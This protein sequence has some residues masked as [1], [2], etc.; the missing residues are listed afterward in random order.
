MAQIAGMGLRGLGPTSCGLLRRVMWRR[1]RVPARAR[2]YT[3]ASAV[4]SGCHE[5]SRRR[6]ARRPAGAGDAGPLAADRNEQA[7][8]DDVEFPV[9]ADLKDLGAATF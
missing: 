9:P 3:I 6:A 8:I 2:A 5:R 4:S 1:R 7:L